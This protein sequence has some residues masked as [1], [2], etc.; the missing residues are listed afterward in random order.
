MFPV[1]AMYRDGDMRQWDVITTYFQANLDPKHKVYIEDTNEKGEVKYWL[2][3]KALY[4]LKQSSHEW[5]RKFRGILDSQKA[6]SPNTSV[7]KEPTMGIMDYS[8]VT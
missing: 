3:H 5:Y 1:V 7:M 8:E 6:D 4:G 2:V